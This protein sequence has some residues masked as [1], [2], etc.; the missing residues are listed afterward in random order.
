MRGNV[1]SYLAGLLF[2]AGIMLSGMADPANVL[3]FFDVF[4]AWN[5]T[6]GFVMAGGLMVS[7]VGYRYCMSRPGPVCAAVYQIPSRQDV[8]RRLVAGAALFGIGWGM[9]GYCPGPAMI[10]AGGGFTEAASFTA[11][12]AVGMLAWRMVEQSL[13]RSRAAQ[14]A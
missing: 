5:P 13:D 12:M 2:G 14:A 10:A 6:L 9:A 3:G 4:G 1:S 7:F 11:A 8:D